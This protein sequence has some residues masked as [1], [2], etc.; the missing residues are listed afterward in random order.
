MILASAQGPTLLFV[1]DFK[2]IRMSQP[3][4]SLGSIKRKRGGI[5]SL[6][7]VKPFLCRKNAPER[8]HVYKSDWKNCTQP[9]PLI[10]VIKQ[11]CSGSA[12]NGD[13]PSLGKSKVMCRESLNIL[14]QCLQHRR[15]MQSVFMAETTVMVKCVNKCQACGTFISHSASIPPRVVGKKN[16]A[17]FNPR[18][19]HKPILQSAPHTRIM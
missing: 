19:M 17:S 9:P 8:S 7:R 4:R 12:F 2:S 18:L 16:D 6:V 15:Q 1:P 5:G 14:N 11:H 13:P 3:Y 10:S